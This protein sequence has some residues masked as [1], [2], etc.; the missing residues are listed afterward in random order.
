MFKLN[1]K[2]KYALIALKHMRNKG[3]EQLTSVKEICD[4][5]AIPFDP[6]A[7]SLQLLA[8][9]GILQAAQGSRGGYQLLKNL[10]QVSLKELNEIIVGPIKMADCLA[11]EI[12]DCQCVTKCIVISPLLH[13]HEK[14]QRFMAGISIGSLISDLPH[15]SE[16]LI[17]KKV[18]V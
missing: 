1:K 4:A 7:R 9:H 2:V 3:S 14:I 13:L 10:D 16:E 11:E 17:K 12:H 8:Q 15:P 5:Y 18:A 6:T